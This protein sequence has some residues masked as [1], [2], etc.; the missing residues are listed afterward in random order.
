MNESYYNDAISGLGD[1]YEVALCGAEGKVLFRNESR[2]AL[3]MS[4]KVDDEN[5]YLD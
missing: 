2:L 5:V 4:I 1:S 3:V